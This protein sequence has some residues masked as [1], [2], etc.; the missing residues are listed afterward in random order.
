M[1]NDLISNDK[2]T[3]HFFLY[4][5]HLDLVHSNSFISFYHLLIFICN[6]VKEVRNELVKENK[7]CRL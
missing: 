7:C 4:I 3:L 6:E 5:F 1:R 2:I